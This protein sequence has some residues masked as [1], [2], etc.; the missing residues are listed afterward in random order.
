M[1]KK[2][3]KLTPEAGAEWVLVTALQ[4]VTLVALGI[5]DKDTESG[6]PE[7]DARKIVAISDEVL[8]RFDIM[9]RKNKPEVLK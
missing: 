1:A 6:T 5:I 2:L 4:R 9:D 3:F 8:A 7:D